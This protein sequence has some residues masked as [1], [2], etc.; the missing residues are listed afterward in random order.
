[1]KIIRSFGPH[2]LHE[3]TKET[4]FFTLCVLVI[5]MMMVSWFAS[6]NTKLWWLF[7]Y[8]WKISTQPFGFGVWRNFCDVQLL[9]MN[10]QS[11]M[12]I[13]HSDNHE[14]C[15]DCN[16]G[17]LSPLRISECKLTMALDQMKE[18]QKADD[19]HSYRNTS[20][21]VY[22]IIFRNFWE[23]IKFSVQVA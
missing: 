4:K 21:V 23:P 8:L 15:T 12:D 5:G 7:Q 11:L 2:L 1:M 10:Q 19:A 3:M 17:S 13:G 9:L 14:G 16:W 18:D 22:W 6:V 20:N